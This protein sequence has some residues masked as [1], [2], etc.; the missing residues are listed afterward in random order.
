[1]PRAR[2]TTKTTAPARRKTR[3]VRKPVTGSRTQA[4][5]SESPGLHSVQD[6]R[7]PIRQLAII[8]LALVCG[9]LGLAVHVFW[10]AAIVLMSVLFGLIAANVRGGRGVIP[11]LVAEV[12][13]VA[14]DLSKN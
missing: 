7:G 2:S 3:S 10:L 1:M 8:A 12:Q 11:E 13:G 14:D 4:V 9:L 6:P 5:N